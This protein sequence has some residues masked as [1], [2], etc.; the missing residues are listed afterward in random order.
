MFLL[1]FLQKLRNLLKVISSI[2]SFVQNLLGKS[3]LHSA[4]ELYTYYSQA[5]F[6]K[7][8]IWI[9]TAGFVQ[10]TNDTAAI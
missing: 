2:S 10:F 6:Q 4:C 5:N 1:T 8:A 3:D 9:C 7:G